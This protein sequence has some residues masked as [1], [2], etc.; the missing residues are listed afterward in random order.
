MDPLST[1]DM[2]GRQGAC[3]DE[4]YRLTKGSVKYYIDERMR[5]TLKE[6]I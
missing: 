3:W 6:R 2:E 5:F 4:V 1:L